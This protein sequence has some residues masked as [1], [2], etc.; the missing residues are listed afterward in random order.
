MATATQEKVEEKKLTTKEVLDLFFDKKNAIKKIT[1]TMYLHHNDAYITAAK[2]HLTDKEGRID[3]SLLEKDNIQQK[4]VDKMT[5]MYVSRAKEYFHVD[6]DVKLDEFQQALLLSAYSGITRDE[7]LDLVKNKGE[8]FDL[9]AFKGV[10]DKLVKNVHQKL[11]PTASS[12]IKK[13]H[14]S[15]LVKEIGLEG[16][17]D[18]EKMKVEHLIQVL[19]NYDPKYKTIPLAMYEKEPY[20]IKPK[21]EKAKDAH[22]NN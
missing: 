18:P 22:K 21:E 16:K 7:L 19:H 20:F 15:D 4:F 5:D 14:I 8:G 10:A 12:H 9:E 17:L 1:D 6:K 2:E 3:Y 11:T 13:E